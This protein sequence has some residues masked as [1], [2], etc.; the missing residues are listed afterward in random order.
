M[1][2]LWQWVLNDWFNVYLL[3]YFLSAYPVK[4]FMSLTQA[5][6]KPMFKIP[7]VFFTHTPLSTLI[8]CVFTPYPVSFKLATIPNTSI[9]EPLDPK[10]F[11]LYIIMWA[12]E[13]SYWE[14]KN[15]NS[16]ASNLLSPKDQILAISFSLTYT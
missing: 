2:V 4:E 12:F 9:L 7:I 1:E 10:F 5:K 6:V 11:S 3:S 8:D 13:K 16:K 14:E 15:Q